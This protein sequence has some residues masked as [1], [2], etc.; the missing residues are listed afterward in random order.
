MYRTA[1]RLA[2][3][4]LVCAVAAG[5]CGVGPGEADE[6]EASLVVTRDF[7]AEEIASG[8][9]EGP[10]PSDSVVRFLDEHA[11][12]ETDYGDNFVSAI[13]GIEGST[14]GGED[15]WF[16]YVN[17]VWSDIGAGEARVHSGDRIWWDYR[18]S[19]VAYRVPAVVGSWPEPFLHGYDDE[20]RPVVVECI[21]A[22]PAPCETVEESLADVGVDAE[23]EQLERPAE[24][25]D[26]LRILVGPWES[27]RSD[28]AVRQIEDGPSISGVY[29]D[30]EPCDEGWSVSIL[31]EDG[32]P[33]RVLDS[34]GLVAA[35]RQGEDEPTWV[36][37]AGSEDDLA[38][39][40]E[41]LGEDELSNRYA[42]AADSGG[43]EAI[44][45]PAPADAAT[46]PAGSC[47]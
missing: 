33:R 1:A 38:A 27:L 44:S 23:S 40:A 24:H 17:G 13:D 11:D 25:P 26:S 20:V 34:G 4:A 7:G 16:F 15:D 43:G 9:L 12:I 5:G 41:L 37:T 21:A 36:V 18:S 6:G 30:V 3:T 42:V 45:V 14:V 2:A 35:V 31:G 8:A 32:R 46:V 19:D 29:A 10:T 47:S 28:R 22:E 39:A